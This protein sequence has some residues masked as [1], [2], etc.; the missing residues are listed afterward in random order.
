MMREWRDKKNS[1][2]SGDLLDLFKQWTTS[3][4]AIKISFTTP[5]SPLYA[6]NGAFSYL[7]FF[8]CIS[9]SSCFDF[10]MPYWAYWK[11]ITMTIV[12]F[13]YFTDNNVKCNLQMIML[14]ILRNIPEI[15]MSRNSCIDYE[16][17]SLHV[18]WLLIWWEVT[19]VVIKVRTKYEN[20]ERCHRN[21]KGEWWKVS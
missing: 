17:E 13:L 6:A 16:S 18:W 11:R 1:Q 10:S 12:E 14:C 20:G 3:L 9:L 7:F 19:M 21:L 15:R 5:T 8:S 2:E 4:S